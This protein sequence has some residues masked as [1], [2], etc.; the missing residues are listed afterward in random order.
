MRSLEAYKRSQPPAPSAYTDFDASHMS[1]TASKSLAD[2]SFQELGS[3]GTRGHVSFG[4]EAENVS[5]TYH[6]S[7]SQDKSSRG[8]QM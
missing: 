2:S 8:I 4:F 1:D 7:L 3:V 5:V 6:Y